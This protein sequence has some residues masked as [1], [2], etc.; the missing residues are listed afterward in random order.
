MSMSIWDF[1]NFRAM[2]IKIKLSFNVILYKLQQPKYESFQYS[3]VVVSF[4]NIY[5]KMTVQYYEF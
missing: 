5:K 3:N 2:N 1:T 4:E